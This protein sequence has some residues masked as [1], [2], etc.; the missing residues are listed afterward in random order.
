MR[1]KI[2]F[3][4]PVDVGNALEKD[5]KAGELMAK[6]LE[7]LKPEAGYMSCGG[8]RRGIIITNADSEEELAT[9]FLP[10]WHNFETY[11]EVE[12]VLT[13]E[14]FGATFAKLSQIA[15]DL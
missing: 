9:Q 13:L 4:L 12:P 14:E 3:E 10:I 6:W 1:F 11:V 15:K 5:P 7:Q 2:T 8:R